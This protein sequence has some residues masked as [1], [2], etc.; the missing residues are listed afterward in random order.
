MTVEGKA[1]EIIAKHVSAI[2]P[3]VREV[4]EDIVDIDYYQNKDILYLHILPYRSARLQE[5]SEDFFVCYD[6]DN[7]QQVVGF[8]IHYFSLLTE[9]DDPLLEP[10]LEMRFDVVDSDLRQ[11]SLREILTWAR[12]RFHNQPSVEPCLPVS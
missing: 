3:K 1:A 6:W 4:P 10:Y 12:Q 7:P 8:E 11:A 5:V 2:S 9:L